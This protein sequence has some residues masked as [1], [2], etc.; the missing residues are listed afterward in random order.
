[1]DESKRPDRQ[2][3]VCVC[4]VVFGFGPASARDSNPDYSFSLPPSPM[5]FSA[6]VYFPFLFTSRSHDSL[7]QRHFVRYPPLSGF[8][9]R[10]VETNTVLD[11]YVSL[12]YLMSFCP[13]PLFFYVRF[14]TAT[15]QLPKLYIA[16]MLFETKRRKIKVFIN[17]TNKRIL[18]MSECNCDL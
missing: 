9:S 17:H 6:F 5:F 12:M 13:P 8:P 3:L 2:Y 11:P 10:S 4:V 1:M 7:R 14:K 16:D 18:V 15:Q